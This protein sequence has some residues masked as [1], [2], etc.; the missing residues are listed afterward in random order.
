MIVSN[1]PIRLF[2][3]PWGVSP[4]EAIEIL[5]EQ[6]QSIEL[7]SII[8]RRDNAAS[9][10]AIKFESADIPVYSDSI[11]PVKTI[12]IEYEDVI[13]FTGGKYNNEP[14]TFLIMGFIDSQL[15]DCTVAFSR[16]SKEL[17]DNVYNDMI[18][19]ITSDIGEPTFEGNDETMWTFDYRN[20]LT[21]SKV[22]VS[23]IGFESE[24]FLCQVAFR[25]GNFILD[26]LKISLDNLD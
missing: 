16:A 8:S 25:N 6:Q 12:K 23:V 19:S 10:N 22:A 2:D 14:M 9:N 20:S 11:I 5:V 4:H 26:K 18:N 17:A 3:I 15:S 13:A 1:F 24:S 21:A 7:L